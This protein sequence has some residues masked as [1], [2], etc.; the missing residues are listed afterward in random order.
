MRAGAEGHKLFAEWGGHCWPSP[1]LAL[2]AAAV[3]ALG[4]GWGFGDS[5]RR[6]TYSPDF[7]YLTQEQ[8][9]TTMG[10]FAR[11][12][13]QLNAIMAADP[14]IDAAERERIIDLLRRL[15]DE[16]RALGPGGWPSNHP[17]ISAHVGSLRRDVERAR[18]AAERDP[19]NYFWAG[20]ISGACSYCHAPPV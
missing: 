14:E 2:L 5:L 6:H 7:N 1:A 15:E 13:T 11:L 9:E 20:S 17:R 8:L 18:Q 4:C 12:V 19:P 16:S 10:R 3:L